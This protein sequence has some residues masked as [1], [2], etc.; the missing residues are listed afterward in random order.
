MN[1][2]IH[3]LTPE[4]WDRV[5]QSWGG[6]HV[7][8]DDGT[9]RPCIGCFSCWNRTPGRCVI[10]DGYDDIGVQLHRADEVT[11]ISRYT[12]GGFSGFVKNVFDRCI[13][14]ALPHFEVIDGETHHKKR[15]DEDK[16]YT[17]IFYGQGLGETEKEC[18]RRY[19]K[20]VCANT[21]GHVRDV[22]FRKEPA[23][24]PS[25]GR[26][27]PVPSAGR[28]VLLNGS[29]RTPNGNSARLARRLAG[30]LQRETAAMDLRDW[31]GDLSG[32]VS[33]V[34][35]ATDLVLCTPLY[36][37]GLPSQVIRFLETAQR[38][39]RG[40]SKRVYVLANMGLYESKQL[41][42]LFSAVRQWCGLTGFEYCG[43]LGVSAGELIGVLMQH[44]P[45]EHGFTRNVARGMKRLAL[46]IDGGAAAEEIF[47]EPFCFPRWLYISIAN[48]GW[49][50]AAIANGIR[51]EELFR[52]L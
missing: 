15:Y 50:R 2:L 22:V 29:M 6:W 37:D 8:S 43:G 40:P 11:V 1:L 33:A 24:P 52:Q 18:A 20:A 45:F 51:P 39:Y 7:I 46:A 28:A 35:D 32:L 44:L 5:K 12:Y 41:V 48:S 16:P 42:N 23:A 36:L 38:E 27:D 3:D 17:F 31:L 13:G 26:R 19:V 10:K 25:G 49:K 34:E 9:I 30:Y 21:R 47:A 14:Y 4:G